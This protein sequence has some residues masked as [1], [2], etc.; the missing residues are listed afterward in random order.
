MKTLSFKFVILLAS[1][2]ILISSCAIVRPGEIGFKQRLGRIKGKPIE[3]GVVWFNPFTSR[4][5]KINIRTVEVY[6]NLPLPTKEG[7]SVNAEISLLYHV[8]PDSAKR[9]YVQFGTNYEEVAVLSNFRATAREISSKYYAKELYATER[10]KIENAIAQELSAHIGKY[11]IVIDAVLLKD[12]LLPAQMVKAIEDKTTAEQE[13]LRMEF[14]IQ[15]QKK[16]AER[17]I[18]EAEAIK[19]AQT[20][21][22]SS[23][24]P[25]LI[26]YNQI[27]M[28]KNLSTSPNAKVIVTN[29][30]TSPMILNTG[31]N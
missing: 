26:Q 15:K 2:I 11:G 14:V 27:E 3:S 5:I 12:I 24:T 6:N 1:A 13:A 19:Q 31:E 7:L 28:L 23:L 30:S 22:N 18:I 20:I 4:L 29:G 8:N 9:I 25:M 21:I 16:E 10:N 17:M